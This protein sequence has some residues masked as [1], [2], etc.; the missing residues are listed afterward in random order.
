[1]EV[2]GINLHIFSLLGGTDRPWDGRRE[3][4]LEKE[5]DDAK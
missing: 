2:R 4:S 5:R 3:T 1:M